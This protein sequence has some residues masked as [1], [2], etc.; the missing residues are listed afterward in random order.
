[1]IEKGMKLLKNILEKRNVEF[2]WKNYRR[3]ERLLFKWDINKKQP[4]TL[5]EL[6]EISTF[7]MSF[8]GGSIPNN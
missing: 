8:T 5:M 3:L 2:Y 4:L 7:A 1:M 6:R